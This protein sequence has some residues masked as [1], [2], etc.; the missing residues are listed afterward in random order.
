MYGKEN[1]TEAE[2]ENI[3]AL[4]QLAAGS[5]RVDDVGTA[6]SSSK[7]LVENNSLAQ[8]AVIIWR[9]L[10]PSVLGQPVTITAADV[11]IGKNLSDKEV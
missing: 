9:V 4:S 3:S 6:F 5:V 8:D 1:L 11:L 7:N 2:K 10:R